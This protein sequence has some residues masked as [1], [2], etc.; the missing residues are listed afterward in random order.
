[1]WL[2]A[3]ALS[4]SALAADRPA[5]PA[6]AKAVAD[7]IAAYAGKASAPSVKVVSEGSS[8]LVT[9]DLAALNPT[10]KP[11]GFTYDPALLKFRVY[12]Q[13]DGQWRIETADTPSISGR[14][15]PPAPNGQPPQKPIEMLIENKGL[16][17]TTLLD[18]KL[19]WIASSHG[20]A[21][22][23][24]ISQRGQ[25]FQQFLKFS[26]LRFEATTQSDAQGL[27]TVVSEPFESFNVIM[28]ID[29]KAVA[30]KPADP[31]GA[32]PNVAPAAPAAKP[33]HVDA[34]GEGGIADIA[35]KG[36]KPGPLADAWR[37]FAA[38]PERADYARDFDALKTTVNAVIGDPF[39]LD[40]AFKLD[41]VH[42]A[43]ESGLVEIEG[44]SGSIGAVNAGADSG[45]SERIAVKAIKLPD[46]LVSGVYAPFVPTSFDIGFKASG[47]DLPGAA[48]EW[49]ADAHLDGDGPVLTKEAQDRFGAKFV[50]GKPI[51]IDILPSHI[52]GPS[53]NLAFQ[54]KVTIDNTQPTGS[55][56]IQVPNFDQMAQAAQGLGP[57][58][59][60]K[61]V[62]MI[63]MVKG[64][65]KAGPDGALIWVC[66]IGRDHVMKVNGLPLGKSPF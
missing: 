54:G 63:A 1:V 9:L 59:E 56:T 8:Y 40:E 45:F 53:L 23:L 19:G 39:T 64:L 6:G 21:D 58:A 41:R 12:Q 24:T 62:P 35:L 32:Q 20:G 37:F 66:D 65:S 31:N 14:M 30:P 46:G 7:F 38:H 47:F 34:K 29:P 17:Q 2:G 50:H 27:T 48:Q 25:G 28:D 60:Q 61:L 44:A 15:T 3:T 18:P 42:L 11:A 55:I 43:T 36:F 22:K 5:D 33:V 52:V 26:K 57:Q 16:E 13:D 4:G 51:V 10:L 49:F